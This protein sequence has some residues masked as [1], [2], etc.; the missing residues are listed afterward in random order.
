MW[1]KKKRRI[2]TLA[3]K[4]EGYTLV[5]V[6]LIFMVIS[7]VLMATLEITVNSHSV[8]AVQENNLRA[9][10]NAENGILI[11]QHQ[12]QEKIAELNRRIAQINPAMIKQELT[13]IYNGIS[14]STPDYDIRVENR[15][16]ISNVPDNGLYSEKITLKSIGKSGGHVKTY[17]KTLVLSTVAEVFNHTMVTSGNL[18]LNGAPYIQ[19]DLYVTGDVK[20]TNQSTFDRNYDL[21]GIPLFSKAQTVS[22]SY[23]ALVGNLSVLGKIYGN[24][25][26]IKKTPQEASPYFS[27]APTLQTANLTIQPIDIKQE[28]NKNKDYGQAHE[29]QMEKVNPPLWSKNYPKSVRIMGSLEIHQGMKITVNGDLL[30]DDYLEIEEGG[31]LEVRGNIFVKGYAKLSGTLGMDE[32]HFLYVKGTKKISSIFLIE[33]LWDALNLDN[34][35][36]LNQ[37]KNFLS[38]L[39]DGKEYA[40]EIGNFSMPEAGTLYINGN[41][42]LHHTLDSNGA[43]YVDGE[44]DITKL[45][46]N[47]GANKNIILLSENTIRMTNNNV[48]GD[49]PQRIDAYLY[50]NGD[51]QIDGNTSNLQINGGVFGRSITLN[52]VKGKVK[53]HDDF[54]NAKKVDFPFL[55]LFNDPVYVE[56]DQDSLPPEKSRL[57]IIYKKEMILNPPSGI[58]TVNQITISEIDGRFE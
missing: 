28:V 11:A 53:H 20:V 31:E 18:T 23:P 54:P 10:Q 12:L 32:G 19:G 17:A 39:L 49:D 38:N 29:P 1:S 40:A 3:K 26:E 35:W 42:A 48:Y 43:I 21:L 51:I 30:V 2:Q 50:S 34:S 56:A 7:M 55:L 4:E 45:E 14:N 6:L 16:E 46:T 22:T 27:I 8:V 52:A 44:T 9:E 25:K 33:F 36:V 37:V 57:S 58:P 13:A 15:T 47:N 5:T 41:L 24:G